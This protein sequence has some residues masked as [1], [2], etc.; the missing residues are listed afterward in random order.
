[1]SVKDLFA[2][3]NRT[4]LAENT[5][6]LGRQEKLKGVSVPVNLSFAVSDLENSILRAKN[7]GAN[8]ALLSVQY[9]QN[10]TDS[11]M[12]SDTGN[13]KL[14]PI[15]DYCNSIGIAMGIRIMLPSPSNI[16]PSD[17][18]TWFTNYK[19][20]CLDIAQLANQNSVKYLGI[21]NELLLMTSGNHDKWQDIYTSLKS[22]Y[23]NLLLFL[24][25]SASEY[26]TCIIL[27]L[28]DIIA[29]NLYPRITLLD[30]DETDEN[31]RAAW[32][33]NYSNVNLIDMLQKLKDTYSKPLW[34]TEVGCSPN[35]IA[36]RDT[37]ASSTFSSGEYSEET[38]EFYYKYIFEIIWQSSNIDCMSIWGVGSIAPAKTSYTF[39]RTLAEQIV[40]KYWE[41]EII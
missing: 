6:Y 8:I 15:I 31:M 21:S 28:P 25:M 14:Q 17:I 34:V 33:G 41:G 11:V 40:K 7:I 1:M 32:Y 39:Q 29:V 36:L 38:Q 27:D 5:S 19:Q 23:P 30:T 16:N 4:S 10:S 2:M 35:N 12:T 37:A 13:S 26:K 20:V 24:T 9:N 18:V 3:A 22:V